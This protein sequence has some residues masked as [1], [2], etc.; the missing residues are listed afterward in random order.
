MHSRISLENRESFLGDSPELFLQSWSKP[1]AGEKA[2]V[3]ITHGLSEHSQCYAHVAQ[4]LCDRGFMV[5]AWDLQGHGRSQGKRGHIQNFNDFS[6][7]L[8]SVIREIPDRNSK[9]FHLMG[10]SMGGLITLQ[11]LLNKDCPKISSATLSNP[12]LGLS[13]NVPTIKKTT[14][15]WLHRFWPSLTLPTGIPYR[16]LSRDPKMM[17]LYAKDPLRH[18]R[19]SPPLFLG[20]MEAMG[21]VSKKV[22]QIKTPLFFQ[23]SEAD[24][25]V[26]AK[27]S[28]HLV[29]TMEGPK[30][31]KVYKDSYHEIYN[32]LNKQESIG[33]LAGYLKEQSS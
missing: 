14:A 3:L 33:D 7:D 18:S 25:V 17:D 1:G 9:S 28:I 4:V 11:A 6:R 32:D 20:M 10:H 12:A 26:N 15:Q 29:K 30:K 31:L 22:H 13:M 2:L 27:H 21:W 19:I 24:Q 23:I 8:I 5:Y 16:V